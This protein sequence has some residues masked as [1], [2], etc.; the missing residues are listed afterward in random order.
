VNASRIGVSGHSNG[1]AL[2]LIVSAR[3]A[4][5]RACVSLGPKTDW[6]RA[7]RMAREWRPDF[8]AQTIKEMN[9][10]VSPD[11]DPKPYLD[12]SPI[13]Y[14]KDIRVPVL[15]VVGTQ[16]W[17]NPSYHC[18]WMKQALEEH[19]NRQSEICLIDEVDHFFCRRHFLGYQFEQVTGPAIRWF[20]RYLKG[21]VD[22]SSEQR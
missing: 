19:G 3:D 8:Y 15:L 11:E 1:A 16:D 21:S 2:A 12:R 13:T 6:V 14:A 18:V 5:V 9:G 7:L 20:D 4:R 10:G 22:S 17:V